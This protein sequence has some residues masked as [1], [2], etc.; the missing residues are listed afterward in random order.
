MATRFLR[1]FLRYHRDLR[2]L[3][4]L[5]STMDSGNLIGNWKMRELSAM[6]GTLYEF[7]LPEEQKPSE[8]KVLRH[9]ILK[10]DI[11]D[12]SRLT[13][14]LLEQGMNPASYFSLNFYDPVNKLLAKYGARKVFVEGDAIIVALLEH[15]GEAPLAVSRA[16]VLAREIIDIVRGY[17]H[18][19]E[20]AGLPALELGTGISFQDS[21]PMYLHGW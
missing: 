16:C 21:A 3:E 9:V 20:R 6:N 17:N 14:S 2:R 8:D 15:E 1:D 10:A 13:R 19:L 4:A 12:S 18:L 7:L 5:N 11:R